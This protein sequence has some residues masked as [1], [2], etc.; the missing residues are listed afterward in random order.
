[1][2]RYEQS[3]VIADYPTVSPLLA[4][5]RL[6]PVAYHLDMRDPAALF[7][8]RRFAMRDKDILF[9]SNAPVTEIGKAFQLVSTLTQP[10]I[11]GVAV[12]AA[13]K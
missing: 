5:Q 6:V 8:A 3:A 2:L 7:T 12:G 4:A 9:V 13:V 10:A 11:Q 1:M